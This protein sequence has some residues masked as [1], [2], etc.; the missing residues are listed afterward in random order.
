[1]QSSISVA[2]HHRFL[3]FIGAGGLCLFLIRGIQI[4]FPC[5]GARR[6]LSPAFQP[7]HYP[8]FCA[9]NKFSL[10]AGGAG[11][12]IKPGVKRKQLQSPSRRSRRQNK[13]W[14]KG[15]AGTPGQADLYS[16]SPRSGRQT[17]IIQARSAARIRGLVGLAP[18][19]PGL[20][21]T[22]LHPGLY[23]DARIRGLKTEP[24]VSCRNLGNAKVSTYEWRDFFASRQ[25]RLNSVV[26]DAT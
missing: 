12:R 16:S 2:F 24:H 22:A 11:V 18:I 6:D 8:N 4:R 17:L 3:P 23:A 25:R 19:L 13:A 7:C 26:A 5:P 14:G 15:K 21:A 10:L 1:M 20:R 9:E